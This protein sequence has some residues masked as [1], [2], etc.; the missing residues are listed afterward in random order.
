MDEEK[1]YARAKKLYMSYRCNLFHMFKSDRPGVEKEYLSY[2]VP[3]ERHNFVTLKG[4][5]VTAGKT[6]PWFGQPGGGIQY[7]VYKGKKGS[8]SMKNMEKLIKD[9]YITE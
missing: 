8:K 1:Q 5:P 4:L 7:V 6:A 9:G 3:A 2:E